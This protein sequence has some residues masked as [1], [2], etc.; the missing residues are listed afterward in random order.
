M[1]RTPR[2]SEDGIKK[3]L[4]IRA[5]QVERRSRLIPLWMDIAK[6]YNPALGDWDEHNDEMEGPPSYADVFD[7]TGMNDSSLLADGVQ[8]YAFSRSSPWQRLKTED[9]DLMKRDEVKDHLQARELQAYSQLA[10]GVFYDEARNM[11]RICSDFG[12]GVMFRIDNKARGIP[13]YKTLHPKR[14]LIMEDESGEVDTLIRDVWLSPD[15]AVQLFGR[16]GV[17]RGQL[18]QKIQDAYRDG[19]T[20]RFLFYHFAFPLDKFDLDIGRRESRGRPFYSLYLEPTEK[21]AITEGGYW[22][23]SWFGWRW[24]RNPDGSPY[25]GDCPGFMEISNVKQ[26]NGMR[27]D[28]NRIVALAARPPLKATAALRN[29][30]KNAPNDVTY[31]LPGEDFT[32]AMTIG[33]IRPLMEDMSAI[34]GGIH[35]SYHKALFLVLTQNLE[36]T[37]TATEVEGIKGEQAAM[38][39]AFFGRMAVEFLEPM[40]EDLYQLEID[41]GRAPPAPDVLK[42][43]LVKIDLVSPLALL[44]KRYMLLDTTRQWLNEI[45]AIQQ[46]FDPNVGDNV[47][48]EEY[49][50]QAAELYHVNRAVVRDIVEVR[51]RQQARAQ[52]QQAQ[53]QVQMQA[54]QAD[55]QAKAYGAAVKAPEPGS[56]AAKRVAA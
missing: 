54:L 56:P 31:L 6:Y 4:R 40:V 25:A 35:D 20:Q 14:A 13:G 45:M 44:Q 23:K 47:N 43:Q 42:G 34:Q 51:R 18:P 11:V 1:G 32:Q 37:K 39:T 48:I 29:R 12:T 21:K 26:L 22:Y 49:V 19:K 41:A 55:A 38:L 17:A 27:K 52:M 9:D 36:R 53:M 3:L 33:D 16:S 50:R 8:G 7:N 15:Q 30:I 2:I 10:K 5:E 28:F 46:T 24:T